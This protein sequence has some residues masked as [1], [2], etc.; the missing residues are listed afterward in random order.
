MGFAHA[1][2]PQLCNAVSGAV[3]H[4]AQQA[5]EWQDGERARLAFAIPAVI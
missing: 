4:L 2:P 1:Y 3:C 5:P